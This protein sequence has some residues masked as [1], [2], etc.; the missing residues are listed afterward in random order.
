ML[1]RGM[2]RPVRAS[3]AHDRHQAPLIR[4]DCRVSKPLV[5]LAAA[6]PDSVAALAA[7]LGQEFPAAALDHLQEPLAVVRV[8][9]TAPWAPTARGDATRAR[10]ELMAKP[11]PI[12]VRDVNPLEARREQHAA[13]GA[14]VGSYRRDS[15]PR[16]VPAM[17][18]PGVLPSDELRGSL[19][20]VAP[21]AAPEQRD[22]RAAIGGR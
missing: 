6:H 1:K 5:A 17:R 16:A 22:Q 2:D 10:A 13:L 14:G 11:T 8:G 3:A 18:A 4:L 20:L 12:A 7:P 9:L 15:L 21:G 19:P